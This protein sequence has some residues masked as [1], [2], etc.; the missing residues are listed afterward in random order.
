M[1]STGLGPVYNVERRLREHPFLAGDYSIADMAAFP[2]I[3]PCQR[4]GQR[5]EDF[6]K[7]KTWFDA[8]HYRPA[9]IKGLEV[10]RQHSAQTMSEEAKKVLFGQTSAQVLA[11]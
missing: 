1:M 2:W 6:P 8:I 10:G 4:Q 9:V 7:L 5:L 3:V 11:R